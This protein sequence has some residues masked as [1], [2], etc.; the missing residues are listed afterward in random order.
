[1]NFD[2]GKNLQEEEEEMNRMLLS[3]GSCVKIMWMKDARQLQGNRHGEQQMT[4]GEG[5]ALWHSKL[6]LRLQCWHS[7]WVPV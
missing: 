1:M 4:H 5:L 3:A 7:L 2:D 6:I